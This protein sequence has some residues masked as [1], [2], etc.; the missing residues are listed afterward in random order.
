MELKFSG[1]VQDLPAADRLELLVDAVT[2]YAIYLLDRD[3]VI[4]SWN[5]GAER[6]NGYRASEAI[7][8]NFSLFFTPED[9]AADVPA[10]ILAQAGRA[11]RA[12][13]D[14]WRLR[15]DGGRFWGHRW[16][17]RCA[18]PAAASSASPKSPAT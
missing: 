1:S 4:R 13:R 11:G 12:E 3:G 16:P 7:G 15:K 5:A 18:T 14:G 6:I 2:E 8:R 17:S 9:R 10:Q